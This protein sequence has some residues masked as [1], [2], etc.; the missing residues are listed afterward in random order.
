MLMN[1]AAH[2]TAELA[3]RLIRWI[4]CAAARRRVARAGRVLRVRWPL[5]L[6]RGRVAMSRTRSTVCCWLML[7]V[8]VASGGYSRGAAAS[9][10]SDAELGAL[11][12]HVAQDYIDHFDGRQGAPQDPEDPFQYAGQLP[13]G[14]KV[15]VRVDLQAALV[16]VDYGPGMLGKEDD[17]KNEQ[18]EQEVG[19]AILDSAWKA[20]MARTT[21]LRTLYEGHPYGHY[22]P[23][24]PQAWEPSKHVQRSES[25]AR[26]T[27][28]HKSPKHRAAE[29]RPIEPDRAATARILP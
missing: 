21:E 2:L 20:G 24:T 4:P 18:L 13:V 8:C 7:A 25:T 14:L 11:L 15:K 6:G 17:G 10:T 3:W 19:T 27:P 23:R 9:S 28:E 5:W 22:F 16:H 12:Q 1:P 29:S 26:Q